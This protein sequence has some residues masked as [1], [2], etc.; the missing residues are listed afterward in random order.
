MTALLSQRWSG[1]LCHRQYRLC[2]ASV[3]GALR[4]ESPRASEFRVE[5]NPAHTFDYHRVGSF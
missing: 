1:T 5:F 4:L 2:G 3:D